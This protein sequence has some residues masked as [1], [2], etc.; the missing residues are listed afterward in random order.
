MSASTSA[1]A[2][3][4]LGP[5]ISLVPEDH[6]FRQEFRGWLAAHASGAPEP[7][8]QDERFALRRAWQRTLFDGG[9]AGPAWPEEVGGR[10]AGPLHQF[11]YYEELALARAPEA[12][13]TPGIALLGPTLMVLGSDEL[14]ARFLPAIL[15]GEEIYCQGFSEPNAGSD[16]ASLRTRARLDGQEWVIDGQKIWTTW[17]QY[18]DFC[19][20]LC[21]TEADSE[22]HRGL[23]LLICPLDQPGVSVR[24]ITQISGDPEFAEV[25][26]DGARAPAEYAVGAIGDGW[27]TAMILFQFERADQ[28]FTDHARM[29]VR[30]ADIAGELRTA[31]REKLLPEHAVAQAR[32]RLAELW[33]RCQQLRRLNLRVAVRG[34]AGEAIGMGGSIVNLFWGELERD[35]GE[36]GAFVDGVRGLLLGTETSHHLLAS[37]AGTIYSGTSEIQRNIIAERLLGLPR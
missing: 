3:R 25:F 19:F 8:D 10:G 36:L 7:L 16:L 26:F 35:I 14:K 9:W 33:I 1:L 32:L 12:V 34:E 23:T 37:R 20:V 22:R 28:C 18:S 13:N 5:E 11:M 21:R 4:V 31:A 6:P 30:L 17:A 27:A 29:L 24:P 15:S 2:S